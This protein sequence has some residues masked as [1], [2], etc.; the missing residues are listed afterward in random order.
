M[1]ENKI[2]WRGTTVR[3]MRKNIKNL[4]IRIKPPLGEIVVS[5][6]LHTSDRQ[7]A[8]FLERH[9][10]WIQEKRKVVM[11]Q[12][13]EEPRY[14]TGEMHFLWGKPYELR[15]ERSLKKP[16]T[17]MQGERLYM[18]VPAH[19]TAEERRKQ[20]DAFYKQE[21]QKRLPD[22]IAAYKPIVGTHAEEWRF[23]RMKTRWGSCQIPKKRICLNLQLA[24]KP[25]ECLEYVVVHELTHLHEAGHNK[26]FWM[27]VE[28]SY[29]NWKNIKKKLNVR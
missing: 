9:A 14:V 2:E 25:A 22:V 24:E 7:L 26:R 6:P 29:P 21:L 19:S 5:V 1:K 16:F 28:K 12:E 13:E 3:L 4:Y 8:S 17:E 15:V 18:R 27:L 10:D 20:L 11:K 23:R